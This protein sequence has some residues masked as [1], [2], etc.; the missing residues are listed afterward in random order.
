VHLHLER[1]RGRSRRPLAPQRIDQTVAGDDLSRVEEQAREQPRRPPGAERDDAAVV[2]N[3]QRPE[4]QELR[5]S[6]L[7]VRRKRIV[8]ARFDALNRPS[9]TTNGGDMFRSKRTKLLVLVLAALALVTVSQALAAQSHL[10]AHCQPGELVDETSEAGDVSRVGYG[11][12]S[13]AG[14]RLH[15]E[16]SASSPDAELHACDVGTSFSNSVRVDPG[17]SGLSAGDPVTL[18]VTVTL[19]GEIGAIVSSPPTDGPISDYTADADVAAGFT[20]TAPDRPVCYPEDG[21]EYCQAA[22]IGSFSASAHRFVEDG[23]S[24]QPNS[25]GSLFFGDAWSWYLAGNRGDNHGDQ[26]EHVTICEWYT[27]GLSCE[28]TTVPPPPASDYTGTRTI[29]VDAFV[30]DR[31]Q[32]D[33]QLSVLADAKHGFAHANFPVVGTSGFHAALAP[34]PGFEG[35][36]LSYEQTPPGAD[37]PPSCDPVATET[38]EDTPVQ[39]T[40]A[41]D[42]ESPSTL[43]YTLRTGPTHGQVVLNSDGRYTYTPVANFNGSDSF[44]VAATDAGG[45]VSGPTTVTATVNPVD[46]RPVCQAKSAFAT[47]GQTAQLDAECSDTEGDPLTIAIAAQ[48]TKGTAAANGQ[49]IEYTPTQTGSDSFTYTASDGT[50][51]S[52]PAAVTVTN[53]PAPPSLTMTIRQ[54]L[55]VFRRPP[56]DDRARFSGTFATNQQLTCSQNVAVSLNTSV[57]TQTVPASAFQ[58]RNNGTLCVYTRLTSGGTG[59]IKRLELNLA[60]KTFLLVLRDE[61]ELSALTNPVTLRLELGGLH[62]GQTIQMTQTRN[63]WTYTG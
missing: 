57:F 5:L 28:A 55:V 8:S 23:A 48:G 27:G 42:D 52:N 20:V 61:V 32:L 18:A 17:S 21:Q 2:D 38:D 30:G 46:D 58:S 10:D 45:Q 31:L 40:L 63:R 44:Q 47:V 24:T 41:C 3:L 15:A 36:S 19:E 34:A 56:D 13:A 33:G 35:L 1:V 29:L 14:L 49:T 7:R 54:G 53:L 25:L 4:N 22:E 39:G 11:S 51:T 37:L 60:A 43:T 62:A 26:D 9:H 59:G 6:P 16:A 12:A 50:L